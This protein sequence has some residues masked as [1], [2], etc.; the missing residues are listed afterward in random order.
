MILSWIKHIYDII[1]LYHIFSD[2]YLILCWTKEIINLFLFLLHFLLQFLSLLLQEWNVILQLLLSRSHHWFTPSEFFLIHW[3]QI[4]TSHECYISYLICNIYINL[5]LPTCFVNLLLL[6]LSPSLISEWNLESSFMF[7]TF[8]ISIYD[9]LWN[10]LFLF[11][12]L[13]P[14]SLFDISAVWWFQKVVFNTIALMYWT[15]WHKCRI[16]LGIKP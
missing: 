9:I 7:L 8:D 2:D 12:I 16:N 5:M 14:I 4:S 13:F 10:K 6:L 11:D 3:N 15:I 1:E